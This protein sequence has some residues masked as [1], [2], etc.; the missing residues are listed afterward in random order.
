[1]I[2]WKICGWNR[3]VLTAVTI[4]PLVLVVFMPL[5]RLFRKSK[6]TVEKSRLVGEQ[7]RN[8]TPV[9][10][11]ISLGLSSLQGLP[12]YITPLWSWLSARQRSSSASS[13]KEISPHV[14]ASGFRI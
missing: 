9:E 10:A 6:T 1:M 4:S 8:G 5:Q 13:G 12:T 14:S 7:P 3:F 2:S 11:N